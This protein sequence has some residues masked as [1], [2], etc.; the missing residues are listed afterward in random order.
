MNISNRLK[1]IADMVDECESI[2]DIGTD[3]GY[4]PIYLVKNGI[5]EHAIASD[6]NAGP[7]KR[8]VNNVKA[9]GY[10]KTIL[11]RLGAGLNTIS[12]GEVDGAVIAG[13]GGYLIID[14][15]EERTD[16]VRKLKF[17]VLQPV[18]HAEVLRKHLYKKGYEILDEE[19]CLD[20]GK[21]YE[22][23]KV[24][25]GEKQSKVEDI[26]C[27]VSRILIEKRHPL[28]KEYIEMKIRRN[29]SAISSIDKDTD[30]AIARKHEL[31]KLNTD[32]KEILKCL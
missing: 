22:I 6:I 7:V 31:I 24:R 29:E 8:A 15:L 2:A 4:I 11:C 20:E 9:H 32:L 5:C 12:A 19:L 18:Q 17:L 1:T 21:Y 25:Y 14:I 30:A 28:L 27:N 23:I 3:H 10:D 26:Y 13:M 16:I